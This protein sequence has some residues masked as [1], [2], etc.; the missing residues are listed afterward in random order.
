MVPSDVDLVFGGRGI[1]L[2]PHA[3]NDLTFHHSCVVFGGLETEGTMYCLSYAGTTPPR[4][5]VIMGRGVL[6]LVARREIFHPLPS[7]NSVGRFTSELVSTVVD[8]GHDQAFI[9]ANND[10]GRMGGGKGN[11]G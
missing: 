10:R 5:V 3:R 7:E 4:K 1:L 6:V 8:L 11:R 9:H 2:R